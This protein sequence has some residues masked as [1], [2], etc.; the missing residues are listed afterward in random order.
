MSHFNLSLIVWAKSQDSVHKPQFLR[1]RGGGGG[2][3]LRRF[4]PKWY[5]ETQRQL[6]LPL[7]MHTRTRS[8][9]TLHPPPFPPLH[10]T[11]QVN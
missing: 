4:S 2:L 3:A 9:S 5:R 7:Y 1:L 6:P 8:L 10:L 11:G